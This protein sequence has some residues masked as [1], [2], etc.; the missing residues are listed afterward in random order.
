MSK[1]DWRV[2]RRTY[3]KTAGVAGLGILTT[4]V[5]PAPGL[6]P[7]P[8]GGR[9]ID[10]VERAVLFDSTKCLGCRE[11]IYACK[12]WNELDHGEMY[13]LSKKTW[14][15]VEPNPVF[16]GTLPLPPWARKTCM[17]CSEPACAA[18]CPVS[19]IAKYE[20]GPVLIDEEACIGCQY[21]VYACPFSV[22]QFDYDEKKA[23]KC[24]MC[25]DRIEAG[26]VPYCVKVCPPHALEFGPYAE[27]LEKAESRVSETGGAIYGVAEAGGTHALLVLPKPLEE[28][29]LPAVSEIPYGREEISAVMGAKQSLRLLTEVSVLGVLLFGIVHAVKS[30]QGRREAE[31][32]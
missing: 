12:L 22:M 9:L 5:R 21:C 1:K 10:G 28:H 13:K 8:E 20:E 32:K 17:H 11:C 7:V 23:T 26:E 14:I 31:T 2:D 16:E 19:A 4:T 18:I 6:I 30:R 24:T 27:M 25:S 15:N 3:L 29:R